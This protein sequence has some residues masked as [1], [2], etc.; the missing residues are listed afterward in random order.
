MVKD[1][2]DNLVSKN[3]VKIKTDPSPVVFRG[4]LENLL[5]VIATS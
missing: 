3:L 5:L 2:V 4:K 1:H